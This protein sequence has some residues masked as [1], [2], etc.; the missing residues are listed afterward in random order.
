MPG[1]SKAEKP[2]GLQPQVEALC[3]DQRRGCQVP[4]KSLAGDS[5]TCASVTC[6]YVTP[7]VQLYPEPS[8]GAG[9]V[10]IPLTLGWGSLC[11]VP[12]NFSERCLTRQHRAHRE[13]PFSE[14]LNEDVTGAQPA[15]SR[16]GPGQAGWVEYETQTEKHASEWHCSSLACLLCKSLL[17]EMTSALLKLLPS[18]VMP[19]FEQGLV[20]PHPALTRP[21]ALPPASPRSGGT[22]S[23]LIRKLSWCPSDSST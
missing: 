9:E 21:G 16:C 22:T 19:A 6:F 5:R 20:H 13:L 12:W 15:G 7:G 1:V 3:Q 2:G 11:W 10:W 18:S 14:Q 23:P 4:G 17:Q 8:S